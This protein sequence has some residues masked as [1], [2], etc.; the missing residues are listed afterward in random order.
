[1]T[2]LILI[3]NFPYPPSV[4]ESLTVANGRMIK[5]GKARTFL[6]KA[7]AHYL[8]NQSFYDKTTE[9]LKDWMKDR[10]TGLRVNAYFVE[11]LEDIMTK[12]PQAGNAFK[13]KDV[14]NRLKQLHDALFGLFNI[15]DCNIIAGD[16][17]KVHSNSI[18]D[19][20]S[21][22]ITIEPVELFSLEEV[23]TYIR[24]ITE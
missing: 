8:A 2:K 19:K 14:H 3:K 21:V 15:N 12:S 1:M 4:N 17:Q 20:D 10:K 22:Y 11:S 5:T 18:K 13:I 16:C 24:K 7:T 23:E 9:I 6:N